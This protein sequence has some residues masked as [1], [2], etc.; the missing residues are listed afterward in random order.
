MDA[1]IDLLQQNALMPRAEMA[2]LLD[3]ELEQ[4]VSAIA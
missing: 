1:I 3:M 2:R 4:V